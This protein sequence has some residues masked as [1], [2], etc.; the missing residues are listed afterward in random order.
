MSD[1]SY[2]SALADDGSG[3]APESD[4]VPDSAAV[5]PSLTATI[6]PSAAARDPG[7]WSEGTSAASLPSA[8]PTDNEPVPER[9]ARRLSGPVIGF[10]AGAVVVAVGFGGWLIAHTLSVSTKTTPVA[11][12]SH[13]KAGGI[14]VT[15]NG[16]TMRFPVGWVNVPTSPAQFQQF[17][18]IFESEHRALPAALQAEANDPQLL[19]SFAMLV[20]RQAGPGDGPENLIAV[21]GPPGPAPTELLAELESGQGPAHFGATDLHYSLTKFGNYPGVL[22]T[23]Q[24]TPTG[25]TEYG[26]QAYLESS[27][28]T[29]ITTVISRDAATSEADLRQIVDTIRFT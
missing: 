28:N 21:V 10:V 16:I 14:T 20:F 1:T 29:V 22:V 25:V 4:R 7:P 27:A 23:Y 18:K 11:T 12:S 17:V 19:S 6:D 2:E 8:V 3:M 15:G 5:E 13:A 9:T 26:A 24:M